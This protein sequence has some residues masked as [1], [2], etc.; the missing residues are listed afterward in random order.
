MFNPSADLRD[1]T[2]IVLNKAIFKGLVLLGTVSLHSA[3][4]FR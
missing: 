3:A 2:V 1:E 4:P